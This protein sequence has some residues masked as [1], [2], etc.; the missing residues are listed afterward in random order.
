MN[1]IYILFFFNNIM[2]WTIMHRNWKGIEK[3]VMIF[4]I[5]SICNKNM[6]IY[7]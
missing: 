5:F 4:K 6:E 7:C 1:Y 2:A 3:S